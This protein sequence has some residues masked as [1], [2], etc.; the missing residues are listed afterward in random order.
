MNNNYRT[1]IE[2]PRSLNALNILN[3]VTNFK[4]EN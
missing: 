3:E 1:Y 2:Y 4:K